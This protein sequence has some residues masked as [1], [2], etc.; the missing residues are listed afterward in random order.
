MIAA[1]ETAVPSVALLVDVWP[2]AE[3]VVLDGGTDDQPPSG[4]GF[5]GAGSE[6]VELLST[7]AVDTG[8]LAADAGRVKGTFASEAAES[9][10]K[11]VSKRM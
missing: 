6:T 7:G 5:V 9:S 4:F 8:P 11:V 2:V 1:A 3:S 10:P